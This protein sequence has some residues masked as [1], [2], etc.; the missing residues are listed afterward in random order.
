FYGVTNLG[1]TLECGTVYKITSGGVLTTLHNF[2][3]RK[4]GA[5][6]SALVQAIDGNFYGTTEYS[7]PNQ[8]C[9]NGCGTIF[10]MTPQG[11]VKV[12]Y[13]FTGGA[14]GGN[15]QAALAEASDGGLYGTTRLGGAHS[16][17]TVFRVDTGLVG[18]PVSVTKTGSGLVISDDYYIKC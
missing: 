16:D 17:G 10:R 11:D 7:G 5:A 2:D 14:D 15:P 6:A 1:G 12:V 13:V 18:F 8:Q 3:C 9:T 4:E